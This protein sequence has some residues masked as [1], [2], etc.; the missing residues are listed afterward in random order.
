[1]PL[2]RDESR[3]GVCAV[4]RA[5]VGE[6]TRAG[7]AAVVVGFSD[8]NL[9]DGNLLHRDGGSATCALWC[10]TDFERGIAIGLSD[11]VGMMQ[12]QW[13]IEPG[14]EERWCVLTGGEPALQL[15]APLLM[16]LNRL[17]WR[18][19]VET[20]GTVTNTHL[21][22]VDHVC[23]SPKRGTPWRTAM[24]DPHEIRVVLPGAAPTEKG[25]TKGELLDIEAHAKPDCVLTVQPQDPVLPGSKLA[26]YL[27]GGV[28]GEE[29]AILAAFWEQA[30]KRC[31]QWVFAHPRW[32]VSLQTDKWLPLG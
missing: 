31:V 13:P 11:L 9:W 23:V 8:C 17:G 3:Y 21:R 32:R 1:M 20:N 30:V 19:A 15:D 4:K 27:T 18:V 22:S 25:W 24:V 12:E 26:T 10:D 14:S 29:L 5:I 2:S 16:E 28:D 6:G 7:S